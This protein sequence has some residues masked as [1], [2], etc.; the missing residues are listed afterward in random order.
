MSLLSE[1]SWTREY[2]KRLLVPHFD[3]NLNP[4]NRL[5]VVADLEMF[6]KGEDA[7][8]WAQNEG[9]I[10]QH[11]SI[12]WDGE[13]ISGFDGYMS[14]EEVTLGFW[15]G[16]KEAYKSGR[17]FLTTEDQRK[18]YLVQKAI[19]EANALRKQEQELK[20]LEVTPEGKMA[21]HVIRKLNRKRGK[22]SI[23]TPAV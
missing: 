6:K 2:I 7:Y 5:G 8:V 12:F 15:K 13:F 14:K 17:V 10:T 18:D 3:K 21:A 1:Q 11:Y 20:K 22:K 19:D 16:F 4:E 23:P 9:K